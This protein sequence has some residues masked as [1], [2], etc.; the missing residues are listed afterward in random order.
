MIYNE[1][2]KI[3]ILPHYKIVTTFIV[4]VK[5][6]GVDSYDDFTGADKWTTSYSTYNLKTPLACCITLP[7]TSDLS[8]ADNPPADETN[9]YLNEVGI[10]LYR[11][12]YIGKT[13]T[14]KLSTKYQKFRSGFL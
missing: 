9:N 12:I 3:T 6:C 10:L 8:C 5:C 11:Y 4:Q 1:M 2:L 7:D 13:T 14:I